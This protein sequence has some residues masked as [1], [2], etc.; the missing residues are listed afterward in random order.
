MPHRAFRDPND[1]EWN[2]WDVLPGWTERRHADRRR[3]PPDAPSPVPDR[4]RGAERRARQESKVRLGDGLER[5]WLTF[6][7]ADEKRRLAPIPSGWDS[8]S[9]EELRR[10][11]TAARIVPKRHGRLIE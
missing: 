7:S 3:N 5:G 2:V 9:D 1:H 4:R 6:E 11:W 8:L 10:L